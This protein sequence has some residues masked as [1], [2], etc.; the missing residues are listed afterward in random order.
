VWTELKCESGKEIQNSSNGITA[1]AV[2]TMVNIKGG[3]LKRN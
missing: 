1:V 2:G 3:L